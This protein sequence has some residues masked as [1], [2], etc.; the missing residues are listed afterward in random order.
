MRVPLALDLANLHHTQ[1]AIG[2]S[3]H[4]VFNRREPL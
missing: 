1:P 3:E 2:S 4:K